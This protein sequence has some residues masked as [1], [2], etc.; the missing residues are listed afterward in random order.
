MTIW[1]GDFTRTGDGTCWTGDGLDAC[2]IPVVAYSGGYF[3]LDA[4]VH[5]VR[6]R[7]RELEEQEAQAEQIKDE[8]DREIA[9]LLRKQDAE[10]AEQLEMARLSQL[11][12]TFADAKAE[13]AY[14]ARV[15]KAMA[16][17][18]AIQSAAT[19]AQLQIELERQF[20]EEEVA[21]LLMIA[22]F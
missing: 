14:N 3:E 18:A 22:D 19:L 1:T 12:A 4:H 21:L 20:D 17:A 13:E 11:V 5:G 6:K 15:S 2:A 9:Q 8:L 16:R 7:R 10:E